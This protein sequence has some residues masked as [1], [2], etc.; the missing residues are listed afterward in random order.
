LEFAFCE[1]LR[2]RLRVATDRRE[3]KDALFEVLFKVCCHRHFPA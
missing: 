1:M 3:Y 2:R